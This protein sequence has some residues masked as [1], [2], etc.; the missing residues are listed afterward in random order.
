MIIIS[1]TYLLYIQKITDENTLK[2]LGELTKQ[3]AAK[4]EN[5]IIQHKKILENIMNQI[6]RSNI[7]EEQEIFN[8]YENNIANEEFSRLAIMYEDG[9]TITSDGKIVDL[10]ESKEEFFSKGDIQVSKSRKSKVDEEEIN[11]YSKKIRIKE[12]N[13][14]ILLVLETDKYEEIFAESIYNGNG[15]EYIINSNGEIIANSKKRNNEYNLFNIL[16]TLKDRYNSQ[17]LEEMQEQIKQTQNGQVKYNVSGRYYYTS[18][19][20]LNT[21]D[22]YLVIITPGSL[23]AQE[24]NKSLKITFVASIIINAMALMISIYIVLSNKKKKEKLYELAYIDKTTNLG[25]NNYFIEKGAEKLH[26]K[27]FEGYLIIVDIDKFKTFNKKYGREKGDE[28]LKNIGIKIKEIFGENQIITRL[29]NDIFGIILEEKNE[30]E[31]IKIIERIISKTSNIKIEKNEYK[32]LISIGISKIQK[33]DRDIFEVLDKALIAHNTGKGD[34]NKKYYIFN[35]K[36]EN[37][38][39]KEHDIEIIMEEGIEKEEFKIFYQPKI[40]SKT[41]KVEEAEALVRWKRGNGLISPNEFI[42]IFEKNKFIIQLDRYVFEKVCQ[43]IEEWREKYKRK[44]RIS[45]NIS[46]EHL[47]Q[48]EFVKE[49]YQIAKKHKLDPEKIELEITES[50]AVDEQFNMLEILEEI[51][52]VGFKIAIDDFG[53]GYS[54]LNMLQQMPVDVIKIDKSFINQTKLLETIMLIAKKMNLK[55]VAEGVETIDQ[56][57]ILKTL[58]VDLLQGYYYSK[59]LEKTEF[60]K[61]WQNN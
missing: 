47:L 43:N 52:K 7:T 35:E 49:Y 2:N 14:V 30:K 46:K 61:Y 13:I 44:I 1:I 39:M 12:K 38:I 16:Q 51:K 55:T 50:A 41:G 4:I 59:P 42:P 28:L 32:I 11:I 54:S 10:S 21:N 33:E 19:K 48:R 26:Q 18:Y 5:Q 31:M 45:I 8:I 57:K 22:W 6:E 37:K 9:K 23:V 58:G 53:T 24:Y 36:L 56:V 34:Y 15:Y 3:D 27:D 29:S 40:D 60:E 25:N 17:K 20:Y